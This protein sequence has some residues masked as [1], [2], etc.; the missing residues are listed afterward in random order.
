MESNPDL[1]KGSDDEEEVFD[2]PPEM[3]QTPTHLTRDDGA[4]SLPVQKSSDVLNIPS[5]ETPTAPEASTSRSRS[6][7]P[8]Q[9]TYTQSA[10]LEYRLTMQASR[11][12]LIDGGCRQINALTPETTTIARVNSKIQTLTDLWN[13]M[14]EEHERFAT[15]CSPTF[16]RH[17]CMKACTFEKVH[18]TYAAAMEHLLELQHQS[19]RPAE[20][21]RP[22][23]AHAPHSSSISLPKVDLPKFDGNA[24]RHMGCAVQW[25]DPLIVHHITAKLDNKTREEWHMHL[26]SSTE[27]PTLKAI[28]EFITN[29][30]LALEQ[31]EPL[32][33]STNQPTSSSALRRPAQSSTRAH[34]ATAQPTT[35]QKTS[36]PPALCFNC[37]GHHAVAAC[38]TTKRCT[39]CGTNHHTM[40]HITDGSST[41][42][43]QASSSSSTTTASTSAQPSA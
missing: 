10:E 40:L 33:A 20:P 23:P 18:E 21:A 15:L 8:T 7:S 32:K 3:G 12:S 9:R 25:W 34:V 27:Y 16:L 19:T 11:A 29:K 6:K 30:A 14:R 42:A 26:G 4:T 24:L 22:P 38:K 43:I 31:L 36:T 41:Q 5:Q 1:K 13:S 28:I 2:V 39:H 17:P 37:L 35:I